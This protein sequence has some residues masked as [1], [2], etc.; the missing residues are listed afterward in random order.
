MS[1]GRDQSVGPPQKPRLC[2]CARM[3]TC[4]CP[5]SMCL[6]VPMQFYETKVTVRL[7]WTHRQAP[8]PLESSYLPAGPGQW[9]TC[10]RKCRRQG[11]DGSVKLWLKV[12]GRH[13]RGAAWGR[14]QNRGTL[15][16]SSQSSI[17]APPNTHFSCSCVP[18]L[19][20]LSPSNS[21]FPLVP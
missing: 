6:K 4:I 16:W 20:C 7:F 19:V 18:G 2:S 1:P 12:Q 15:T 21:I 9:S 17:E 8:L 5:Y 3:C 14:R 13:G 10:L 11:C